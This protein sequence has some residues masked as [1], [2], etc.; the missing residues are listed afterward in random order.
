Q[1]PEHFAL[2]TDSGDNSDNVTNVTKPTLG[3]HSNEAA[4]LTVE[5]LGADGHG[6]QTLTQSVTANESF[7]VDV[8]TEMGDGEYTWRVQATD[9]AGNSDTFQGAN[10][11]IDSSVS[12]SSDT[13]LDSASDLGKFSNDGISKDKTPSFSGVTDGG[14]N[15]TLVIK[16][17]SQ[18]VYEDSKRAGSD[19]SFQI[20]VTNALSDGTYQWT[21]TT[22]DVA[23]N[24]TS[25]SGTYELDTNPPDVRFS[26]IGDSGANTTDWITKN[27]TFALSGTTDDEQTPVSLELWKGTSLLEEIEITPHSNGS[28]NYQYNTDLVDGRY[29]LK[30]SSTDV[31]GN[32]FS[33]EQVVVID[34]D[35]VNDFKLDSDTGVSTTDWITNA[36]VLSVSGTTDKDASVTLDIKTKSGTLLH[37]YNPTVSIVDGS[38]QFEIPDRLNDG[39]Y[40]FNVAV[41]DAAGNSRLEAHDL[42]ID[43]D[44]PI[45]SDI[46]L[47]A[48]S[49]TGFKGDWTTKTKE[50]SFEGKI[51]GNASSIKV[52]D[53]H[54]VSVSADKAVNSDGSFEITLS[55]L[56]FGAHNLTFVVTDIAGN[57]NTRT[58]SVTITPDT[59]PFI[60][61]LDST[62]NSGNNS[63]NITNVDSPIL[64]GQATPGY[65]IVA[66]M[67]GVTYTEVTAGLDGH[68]SIPINSSDVLAEK[69]YDVSL[70]ITDET[71][72]VVSTESFQFVID[73]SVST[74]FNLDGDSDSGDKGDFKTNSQKVNLVGNTESDTKIKIVDGDDPSVVFAS[75]TATNGSWS[76]QFNNLDEGAH[77]FVIQTED[78]AGNT[79]NQNVRVV[80]DITPPLLEVNIDGNQNISHNVSRDKEHTFSGTVHD[81]QKLTL[82]VNDQTSNISVNPDGTWSKTLNLVEGINNFT[83]T[84]I[85]NAGNTSSSR[86]VMEIK[87]RINFDWK[88]V[89]DNGLYSNDNILSGST[90]SFNGSG[91]EGDHVTLTLTTSDGTNTVKN[92]D[93]GAN[94]KWNETFDSLSDGVY[95]IKAEVRDNAGNTANRTIDDLR[96]DNTNDT[97]TASLVDSD[98]V[99]DDGII[100]NVNPKFTGQGEPNSEIHIL[101]VGGNEYT[102]RVSSTGTWSYTVTD[103][104]TGSVEAHIYSLDLAGNKSSVETINFTVDSTQPSLTYDIEDVHKEGTTNYINQNHSGIVVFKG[105]ATEAGTVTID[106]NNA[107]YTQTIAQGGQWSIDTIE[108]PERR[109]P[110]TITFEDKAGSKVSESGALIVDKTINATVHL[111]ISSDS[112]APDVWHSEQDGRTNKD[113]LD[114]QFSWDRYGTDSDVTASVD[115]SGPNGFSHHYDNINTQSN[116]RF[117]EQFS[118]SSQDGTYTFTW[119]F[120]DSAGN[121]STSTS[122]IVRDTHIGTLESNELSFQGQQFED[123]EAL[124]LNRGLINLIYRPK[125]GMEV[126][127]A[128][129][130]FD[131]GVESSATRQGDHWLFRGTSLQ[132]GEN[133]FKFSVFDRAGNSRELSETINLKT[134]FNDFKLNID[135]DE[136]LDLLNVENITTSSDTIDIGGEIDLGTKIVVMVDGVRVYDTETISKNWSETLHLTHD[137][138]RVVINFE[139]VAGNTKFASFN[140]DVDKSAPLVVL[141][142]INGKTLNDGEYIDSDTAVFEGRLDAGSKID[143]I[144]INGQKVANPTMSIQEA[145]GKWQASIDLSEGSNAIKINFIDNAGNTQGL[146]RTLVHDT[147]APVLD[148]LALMTDSG[149]NS[150]NVTNATKP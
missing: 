61:G 15:V 48:E 89:G 148:H 132:E 134:K 81:A 78:V 139:D 102:T 128:I 136:V 45:I 149:D 49:D 93:I 20:P 90:L 124:T 146:S 70:R 18:K 83:I 142:S 80:V 118:S 133:N 113:N 71:G 56:D 87:T 109:H 2:M 28:W 100:A 72:G 59:L 5:I 131:N 88:L 33:K 35:V 34:N 4:L 38:W 95:S 92:F 67:G 123:G 66:T 147:T 40:T 96:I 117:P 110:F 23:G 84:A 122:T 68:W 116:W 10:F 140:V 24:S 42:T 75:M 137:S 107:Q 74:T 99:N 25:K 144:F 98:G 125:S 6:V 21:L 138:Q 145:L 141:D 91:G 54:G 9:A 115:V 52:L 101:I 103:T 51:I 73:R 57:T 12:F 64:S 82:K 8:P 7:R 30:I 37:S 11:I 31:A 41:V 129:I 27:R 16:Q 60:V 86:G 127:N 14:A 121:T 53:S 126:A 112:A 69:T 143:S 47:K 58:Q 1:V 79:N 150:D 97:F 36:N 85:D 62:T 77:N 130:K 120:K 44:A 29:L 105:T 104:I 114:F 13:G 135:G 108:L 19:G 3:G 43:R 106:I 119:H 46:E 65:H 50:L 111:T 32:K 17:G 94:H 63:D 39:D 22:T 26:L 76:Y 55:Q